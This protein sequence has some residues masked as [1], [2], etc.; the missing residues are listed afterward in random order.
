MLPLT[1]TSTGMTPRTVRGFLSEVYKV[2]FDPMS[3]LRFLR[4]S[5]P[6][7]STEQPVSATPSMSKLC[8]LFVNFYVGNLAPRSE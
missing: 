8:D 7:H 4:M 2:I 5:V 3:V 6:P 1:V